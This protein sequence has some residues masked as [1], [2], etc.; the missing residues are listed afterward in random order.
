MIKNIKKSLA[1]QVGV[2]VISRQ[3]ESYQSEK[4]VVD[5]ITQAPPPGGVK[6]EL[7]E[8]WHERGFENGFPV[9]VKKVRSE[10]A[11]VQE[12]PEFKPGIG[13]IYS[14]TVT[15]PKNCRLST[16]SSGW[17]VVAIT[18]EQETDCVLKVCPARE[19]LA[20]VSACERKMR[21]KEQLG[22]RYWSQNGYSC[23]KLQPPNILQ[24]NVDFLFL[25]LCQ[26][27]NST[28]SGVLTLKL[29]EKNIDDYFQNIIEPTNIVKQEFKMNKSDILMEDNSPNIPNIISIILPM[30]QNVVMG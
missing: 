14:V 9:T 11:F 21:F 22:V 23:F 18:G 1:H 19:I 28:V 4:V 3:A 2:S 12:T 30:I 25:A 20:I 16:K 26:D 29:K 27:E 6:L 5:V 7:Q 24:K 13:H 8:F 10:E 17:Q 15:L